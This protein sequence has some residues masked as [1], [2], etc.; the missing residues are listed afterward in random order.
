[1]PNFSS[2][3]IAPCTYDSEGAFSL[4]LGCP[5]WSSSDTRDGSPTPQ[6]WSKKTSA[7]SRV[8]RIHEWKGV[9]GST[10]RRQ[11][12]S[13]PRPVRGAPDGRSEAHRTQTESGPRQTGRPVRGAPD[14]RSE[15]HRTA[16]PRRTGRPVR[17]APDGRW[18]EKVPLSCVRSIISVS[19]NDNMETDRAIVVDQQRSIEIFI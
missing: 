8:C 6:K 18:N 13:K 9:L 14:G 12:R 11:I 7:G 2:I 19:F 4:H 16:G 3:Q 1:M 5:V 17:G 15:A 10:V